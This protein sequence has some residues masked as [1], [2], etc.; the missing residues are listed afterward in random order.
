MRAPIGLL[1]NPCLSRLK[2]EFAIMAPVRQLAFRHRSIGKQTH[3]QGTAAAHIRYIT[4]VNACTY[5]ETENMPDDRGQAVTYFD[6]LAERLGE[7]SNARICD[8]LIIA[9][10]LDLGVH[11]RHHVLRSFMRKLGRGRIP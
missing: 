6:R 8:K 9:L 7:R 11:E 2:S 5:F 1:R 3:A 10:P 4:R